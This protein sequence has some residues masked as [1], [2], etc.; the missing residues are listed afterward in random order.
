[1][2]DSI[3]VTRTNENECMKRKRFM[4]KVFYEQLEDHHE[5]VKDVV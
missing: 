3:A 2:P 4:M 1:M 5:V